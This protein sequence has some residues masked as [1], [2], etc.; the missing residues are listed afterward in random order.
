MRLLDQQTGIGEADAGA[1][2]D[3]HVVLTVVEMAPQL[4]AE[5]RAICVMTIAG[6]VARFLQ[7]GKAV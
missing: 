7:I 3:I 6:T 5:M 4:I 1:V 2:G